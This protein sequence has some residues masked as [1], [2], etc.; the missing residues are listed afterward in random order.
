MGSTYSHMVFQPPTPPTYR[1]NEGGDLIFTR[2]RNGQAIL[3]APG[4]AKVHQIQTD[5]GSTIPIIVLNSSPTHSK[6][7]L[8]QSNDSR[9]YVLLYSHGNGE[10]L[11][12]VASYT[13]QLALDLKMTV[14]CYDYT[15][16]GCAQRLGNGE[17]CSENQVYMD[18]DAALSFCVNKM[19]VSLDR[20]LIVGRSLGSGPSSYLASK[21][22][23]AGLILISPL[24][25]CVRIVVDFKFTAFF[26]MFAN[27]DRMKYIACPVLLVHGRSDEVVPFRHSEML[28]RELQKRKR[29]QVYVQTLYLE[30]VGHNDMETVYQDM[31]HATYLEFINSLPN[32][33]RQEPAPDKCCFR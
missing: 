17:E 2:I 1:V 5:S 13:E 14:V 20:I 21:N 10:D 32:R 8:Q 33:N 6:S 27:I 11:A 12:L 4:I 3:G 24:A 28:E 30:D 9:D 16:Y 31:M 25:S 23:V 19:K 26:D 18:A 15:G 7:S 29:N 22:A